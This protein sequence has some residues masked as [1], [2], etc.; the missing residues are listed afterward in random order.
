MIEVTEVK[1]PLLRP[2]FDEG[3]ANIVNEINSDPRME[4]INRLMWQGFDNYAWNSN[5]EVDNP[6]YALQLIEEGH[7]F[8]SPL[9][10]EEELPLKALEAY[11]EVQNQDTDPPFNVDAK[12]THD[13]DV[14]DFMM[15]II[16]GPHS[17]LS[18]K[19]TDAMFHNVFLPSWAEIPE[20]SPWK[21]FTAVEGTQIPD[22]ELENPSRIAG[23]DWPRFNHKNR[24][25]MTT[26]G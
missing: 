12:M 15:D 22:T 24:F 18:G 4:A 13:G 10:G 20:P 3:G 23:Y 16:P 25:I 6:L 7:R 21:K 2:S 8:A 9:I 14:G 1:E 5:Q 11:A 19:G 26:N 17:I